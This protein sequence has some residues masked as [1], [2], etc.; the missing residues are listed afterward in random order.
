M[1][2]NIKTHAALREIGRYLRAHEEQFADVPIDALLAAL[3]LVMRNNIVQ[4]GDTHWKQRTG[5]AMGTP[6]APP[7]ATLYF[8]VWEATLLTEFGDNLFFLRRYIDDLLGIWVPMDPDTDL[9]TWNHFQRRLNDFHN[10]EWETSPRSTS[11]DFLDL[12]ISI[13]NHS[14]HTTLYSKPLNLYLYIPP[15]SAHPPGVLTGLIYGIIH[16]TFTLCSDPADVQQ[17]LQQFW[18]RLLARGY[19]GPAIRTLFADIGNPVPQ[20]FQRFDNNSES[21]A[22]IMTT[23]V[24]Y[25]LK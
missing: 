4:F 12:T 25:V 15:R 8:A 11:V 5:C 9:T 20:L 14:I 10:L 16:R 23:Q 17:K 13:R 18:N 24:L 7:Y 1:Y 22:L 3:D 2:T 21:I 6:P 19:E